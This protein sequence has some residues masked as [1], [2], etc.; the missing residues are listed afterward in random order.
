[1]VHLVCRKVPQRLHSIRIVKGTVLLTTAILNSLPDMLNI[2]LLFFYVMLLLAIASTNM[3]GAYNQNRYGD[4][5]T[6]IYTCFSATTL[7][8]FVDLYAETKDMLVAR[9]S[10]CW[11]T[12]YAILLFLTVFVGSF[13]LLNLVAAVVV[14]SLAEANRTEEAATKE[15]GRQAKQLHKRDLTIY[16]ATEN[17]QK[18]RV[19]SFDKARRGLNILRWQKPLQLTDLKSLTTVKLESY[20]LVLAALEENLY[21]YQEITADVVKIFEFVKNFK[22]IEDRKPGGEVIDEDAVNKNRNVFRQ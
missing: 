4:L 16:P 1:M 6:A 18:L 13:I 3:F 17:M 2:G 9:Q 12:P 14:T 19:K 11:I 21:E 15:A 7:D 8:G 20:F 10:G 22:N 5:G